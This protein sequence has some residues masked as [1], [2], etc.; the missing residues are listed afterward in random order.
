MRRVPDKF[1]VSREV[2][3]PSSDCVRRATER[4]RRPM[5]PSGMIANGSTASTIRLSIQSM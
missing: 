4:S 2:M 5:L 3:S 1:S